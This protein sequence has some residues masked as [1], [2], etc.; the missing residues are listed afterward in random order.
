MS[1]RELVGQVE[2]PSGLCGGGKIH[3]RPVVLNMT[4][5]R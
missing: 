1:T 4:G 5:K 2:N 3:N